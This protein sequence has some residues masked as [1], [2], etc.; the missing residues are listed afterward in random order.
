MRFVSLAVLLF[1]AIGGAS[2]AEARN[3]DDGFA[4]DMTLQEVL[5]LRG[6]KVV[7]QLKP[8]EKAVV[9]GG[10]FSGALCQEKD[11]LFVLGV[12][13]IGEIQ[14]YDVNLIAEKVG[15]DRVRIELY[16]GKSIDR[17]DIFTLIDNVSDI[18]SCN[19]EKKYSKSASS[20]P[21]FEITIIDGFRKLSD[22]AKALLMLESIPE[23]G[24]YLFPPANTGVPTR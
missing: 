8:G 3:S 14:A 24:G 23:D 6:K 11:T 15:N 9:K 13:E 2:S 19:F 21:F 1:L 12:A 18:Y 7:A 22:L 4:V 16:A 5:A 20:L 10:A 17:D